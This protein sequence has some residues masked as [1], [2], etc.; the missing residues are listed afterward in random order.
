MYYLTPDFTE[1]IYNDFIR[2]QHI[3]KTLKDF[4]TE[5]KLKGELE[6][7]LKEKLNI[8]RNLKSAGVHHNIIAQATGLT[9]KKIEGELKVKLNIARNLK[10]AGVHHN[11]IAQA[12]GLTLK[13][14]EGL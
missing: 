11:I 4:V 12:T 6:G 7:E 3:G 1:K 5:A 14:I 13:K 10:S 2:M 9:L 8:A